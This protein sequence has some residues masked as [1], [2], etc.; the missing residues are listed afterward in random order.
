MRGLATISAVVLLTLAAT[1]PAQA[2]VWRPHYRALARHAVAAAWT[3]ATDPAKDAALIIEADSG[4]VLYSR[5]AAV[6][7]HP[8][9]LTKMMTLYLLFDAL[10]KGTVTLNTPLAIS[11]HAAEQKPTNLHLWAGDQITVENAIKAIVIR[12]A[13]DVAVAIAEGLGGTESHF[14]QMMTQTAREMGMNNTYYHNASGLPDMLQV[15]TASDLTI[16][17]RHL[18]TDF[19][20][21]FPYFATPS[22]YYRGVN[23]IT[24]DNLIGR[25]QG[26]EGI[27]TGFTV[28]SGF[29]LVSCVVRNGRRLIGV[30]MGG[31]TAARRDREMMSLLD[32]AFGAPGETNGSPLLASL[33]AQA[34]AAP[35]AQ[36]GEDGAPAAVQEQ[37]ALPPAPPAAQSTLQMASIAPAVP[38]TQPPLVKLTPPAPQPQVKITLVPKPRPYTPPSAPNL[39]ASEQ[40]ATNVQ[41]P[42]AG[43]PPNLRPK[44]R[45]NMVFP[46]DKTKPVLVASLMRPKPAPAAS[47]EDLGEGDIG[48]SPR[49]INATGRS[50]TIQI[51][52]YADP[53]SAKAQLEA[54]A[55]KSRDLLGQSSHLVV[56]AQNSSGHKMYRARFGPFAEKEA[57]SVCATLTKRGQTCFTVSSEN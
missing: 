1:L 38:Y 25:Y 23:Y 28:A 46:A 40:I 2:R 55:S 13:N 19:P 8:A 53:T 42:I 39:R 51:G 44:P 18:R 22:F 48:D 43:K 33:Q 14:A 27:K 49:I 30:V 11:Q 57:R 15:T 4:R 45:P 37:G 24:H 54:Y 7:R 5:N 52:A 21:Y 50:W 47:R 12:S 10:K 6:S 34:A 26:T 29:N 16:L 56:S 20:Q 9:S 17:A 35:A 41:P 36:E 32:T 3:S 31:R